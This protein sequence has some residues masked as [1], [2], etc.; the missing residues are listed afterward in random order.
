MRIT[1]DH[2][3]GAM[4]Y[5]Q[6]IFFVSEYSEQEE[7]RTVIDY[8]ATAQALNKMLEIKNDST[9]YNKYSGPRGY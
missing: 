5:T 8:E 3:K 1:A 7:V 6:R 2:I 9:S 4:K